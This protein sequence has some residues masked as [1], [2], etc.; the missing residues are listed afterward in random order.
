MVTNKGFSVIINS[1]KKM[2]RLE[3]E[4]I[5]LTLAEKMIMILSVLVLSSITFV[6]VMCAMVFISIGVVKFLAFHMPDYLVYILLGVLYLL[7]LVLLFGFKKMLIINPISRVIS[8]LI[9]N[10][11]K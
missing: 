11:P 1:I 4:F 9:I 3:I 8:K 7:L 5:K 6:I 10:S 2:F